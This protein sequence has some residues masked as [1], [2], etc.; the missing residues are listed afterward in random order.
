MGTFCTPNEERRATN[1]SKSTHRRANATWHSPTGTLKEGVATWMLH[2]CSL[3]THFLL[4]FAHYYA[5]YVTCLRHRDGHLLH[6]G[7]ANSSKSTHRR[8]NATW[9]SPTGT[10]KEGVATWMLHFCS[11]LLTFCS[12]LCTICNLP[13]WI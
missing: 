4:T 9:H 7:A 2:F 5:Q 3:F 6:A 1:S 11:L 10:L 12:L 13:C 8:A